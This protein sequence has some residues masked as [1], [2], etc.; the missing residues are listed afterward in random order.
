MEGQKDGTYSGSLRGCLIN[1]H[2]IWRD[3]YHLIVKMKGAV[4]QV[5]QFQVVNVVV[6]EVE[7]RALLVKADTLSA[8]NL[9]K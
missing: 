8:V 4:A 9:S 6:V 5:A 1:I 3:I 2:W 7:K